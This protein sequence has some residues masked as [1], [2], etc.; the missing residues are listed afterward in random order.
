M[1]L[2]RALLHLYPAGIPRGVRRRTLRPLRPAARRRRPTRSPSRSSGS[3]PSPTPCSSAI[4]AHWDILRRDLGWSARSLR[5]SPAFALTAIAVSALG[6]G[7]TTAAFTLAD[8]VLLRPLP[9]ADSDRLVKIW[10]D[11]S[12][13]GYPRFDPSPA[14]Y[15]DWKRRARSFEGIDSMVGLSPRIWS[16]AGNP[17]RLEGAGV[18]AGL[19]PMLGVS[20]PWDAPSRPRTIGPARPEPSCSATRCGAP[21]SAPTPTSPGRTVMLDALPYTVIGVMPRDFCFPSR[22]TQIWMSARFGEDDF[23]DRTNNYIRVLAKLRRGVTLEAAQ[24]EMRPSPPPSS[25]PGPRRTNTS[26]PASTP[27]ATNF[28]ARSRML[29][30]A[31]LGAALCVLLIG[32][33]N[34]ANLLLARALA[35]R[36]E[37]AVRTAMG[38]GRET[39][40]P[41]AAHREPAAG[42]RRRHRR[43]PAGVRRTAAAG[44]PGPQRPADRRGARRS[45][46]ACCWPPPA[47][48]SSPRWPSASSPPC[49]PCGGD[50]TGLR[51]GSRGGA[52]GRKERLRSALVIAEIAG[53]VVLLVSSGLLAAR[54]LARADRRSRIPH[55]RRA[56]PAH[57]A[58]HAA[59]T[60]RRPTAR[61]STG[62]CSQE[63]RRLPGVSG[64]AYVSAIPLAMQG[65]IWPVKVPGRPIRRALRSAPCCATSRPDYFATLGIPLLRLGRDVSEADTREAPFAAVVSESF[66]RRYWPGE[67][68]LGRHFEFALSDRTIVG[69]V[70]DIRARG[71]ERESEPQVYLPYR[72]V[73]DNS[74]IGYAPKDLVL[75]TSAPPAAIA[76]RPARASSPPPIADL[77]ITD[78]RMLG[79]VVEAETEPR[80]VQVRALAAF[81]LVAFLLAAIGIHGLLSFTVSSRAQE[82]GVRLAL[83]AQRTRH[84]RDDPGRRGAP[85]RR[86]H[87][88]R[89]CRSLARRQ[90]HA[91]PARRSESRRRPHFRRRHRPMRPDG[92]Y[93]QPCARPPRHPHRPCHR[94]PRRVSRSAWKEFSAPA[95]AHPI[96]WIMWGHRQR[97]IRRECG[98]AYRS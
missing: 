31:L 40:G 59:S 76:A 57:R 88:V 96:Q 62:T 55:R 56:H 38:A 27:C 26:A 89:C 39:P 83:G 10:E 46:R 34:L 47:S 45:T 87:S 12:T 28:P 13:R 21:A 36:K 68:P 78:V 20:P 65:G 15:R 16:Q 86:R 48:R 81:A 24:S 1:R 93:R 3:R 91:S 19:L 50:L 71:P 23:A 29:L 97:P 66:A 53:S 84:P 30:T 14:N 32:C 98:L 74:I 85:L 64:A 72:Q 80:A 63:A 95:T 51:E 37:L 2:Y 18:T 5:R 11:D 54:A 52:G 17:A 67:N 25:A 22:D 7:A 79:D 49:A 69:V 82:I 92:S 8:H 6:I 77:P 70:G 4:A 42:P 60:R 9:Y 90:Q 73:P 61:A 35:R 94:H 44:P 58:A 33:T 41:P 43:R 75:R